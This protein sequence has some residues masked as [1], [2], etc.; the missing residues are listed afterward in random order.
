MNPYSKFEH[1]GLAIEVTG[2]TEEAT[3]IWRGISDAR[4]PNDFLGPVFKKIIGELGPRTITVDF[5]HLEFMNSSTVSPIISL[6]KELDR[7]G[8]KTRVVF[9]AEEWQQVHMRC[10]R[11]IARVLKNIT[12]EGPSE[13]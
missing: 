5:S 12:V 10:I 3:M 8:T 9:G 2:A 6:L 7:V 11:T 4:S 1:A 13:D